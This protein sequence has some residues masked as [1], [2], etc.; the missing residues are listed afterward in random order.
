MARELL[1][2]VL[3]LMAV[4]A[5]LPAY[6]LVFDDLA[7]RPP[8]LVA[9]VAAVVLAAVARRLRAPALV[10]LIVSAGALL[11]VAPWL[12]GLAPQ[13]G[14]PEPG[15]LTALRELA[16]QGLVELAET[17]S[18]A[19]A[20]A[21]LVL[22]LVTLTWT[23]AHTAHELLVRR[24][25]T[26]AALVAI[27]TLWAVPLVVPA[28]AAAGSQH[29]VS[30]LA[31]VAVLLL[32]TSAPL[33][34]AVAGRVV[35]VGVAA[36]VIVA[37]ITT[38]TLLPGYGEPGWVQL[39]SGSTP[40]GYQ[41][42]VDVSERLRAP[43]ERDVLRVRAT[44]RTYLRLAGLEHFDG[45]SWRLGSGETGPFRPDPA[46]LISATGPLPPEAPAARVERV[47]VDVEVLE[48]ENIYVPV[49][50]QP[51]EVLGP[52]RAEMVWSTD[53]GFLAT[54]DTT[55]EDGAGALR[56]G[57]RQGVTYRVEAARPTPRFDELTAVATDAA[58]L[59]RFTVLPDEYPELTAK[60]EEIY[61]AAGATTTIE[62]A[63]A[64][65]D[66]FVGPEGGFTYDLE[67][68]ALR[69]DDALT[70]FVLE[71]RV[72]YCEYFATAM[73]VML[74]ATGIPARVAVGFLPGTVVRPA[75]PAA[76]REL[77]EYLVSTADAHAWVEVLFPG[78]GWVTFEPTPRADGTHLLPTADDLAPIEN[79]REIEES[80]APD[81][82]ELEADD[83]EQPVEVPEDAA[84][85]PEASE[86]PADVEAA[87]TGGS[88]GGVTGTRAVL[89]LA[90]LALVLA[91]AAA[92]TRSSSRSAPDDPRQTVTAAQQRL[93]RRA[94]Q[95]GVGRARHETVRELLTR[96]QAEGRSRPQHD[97]DELARTLQAAAFD[98][99]VDE[100]AAQRAVAAT[101]RLVE[102]LEATA[103]RSTL[104]LAPVRVPVDRA[105][106]GARSAAAR[107]RRG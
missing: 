81:P 80:A 34:G 19:P 39:S 101:E 91:A 7:W 86:D 61:A 88:E 33:Q 42:I 35:G 13:L 3:V 16:A 90:G 2:A 100:Q 89:V 38:P 106:T 51:I 76:G 31:A 27:T 93:L 28:P 103:A 20:L 23:V 105:R 98:G 99:P 73:A 104:V 9:A 64:L 30:F 25:F 52:Q 77:T 79:V 45:A 14:L 70:D 75:D 48:L 68:P 102:E 74:R 18:P 21:G 6:S 49:P 22:L 24:R 60:A 1:G 44:Q 8:V 11:T 43:E 41:P 78:Y 67:V 17:P 82:T 26:G 94:D 56:A 69:G 15:Q 57:V 46:D 59:A 12:T 63:L 4:V 47:F 58:E 54:W 96:W 10:S 87:T 85:P 92:L 95:L 65:Q 29:V 50:Y 84:T 37:A 97:H 40:R 72:G 66:W 32:A 107:I 71:D 53:G 55:A 5:T 83:A 36:A 62:R